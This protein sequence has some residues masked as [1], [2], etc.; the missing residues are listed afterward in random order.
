MGSRSLMGFLFSRLYDV[1]MSG[2]DRG[3]MASW[4]H[5]VIAPSSGTVLEIGVGNGL[6][7][8]HYRGDAVVVGVEPE[9]AM[10]RRARRRAAQARAGVHL[11]SADA[12]H[13]PFRDDIFDSAVVQ[14]TLCTIPE[15]QAALVELR[16]VLQSGTTLR[17]LEHVRVDQPVIARL[18]DWLTPVWKRLAGGC[19]LN[20]RT[21]AELTTAG[22]HLTNRV[23]HAGGLFQE[24][25]AHAPHRTPQADGISVS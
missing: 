8:R 25:T 7:L 1:V 5:H 4:R 9:R 24:L 12:R 21:M 6:G 16:R 11:V 17:L 10:L 3:V 18:Q 14:L 15:P 22:F 20:R 23:S 2:S 19:H 13:L